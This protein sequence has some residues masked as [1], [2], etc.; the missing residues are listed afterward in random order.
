MDRRFFGAADLTMAIRHGVALFV[1][2]VMMRSACDFFS[3]NSEQLRAS[4]ADCEG[5]R[6]FRRRLIGAFGGRA[7][8]VGCGHAM[9]PLLD[10]RLPNASETSQEMVRTHGTGF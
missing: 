5:L 7:I 9:N 6:R 3:F 4:E 10:V 2:F 8:L 1:C